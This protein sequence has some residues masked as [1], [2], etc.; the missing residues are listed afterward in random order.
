MNLAKEQS[1]FHYSRAERQ[2]RKV[3]NSNMGA[4][5]TQLIPEFTR[6]QRKTVT[7]QV[8]KKRSL[9]LSMV[10][11]I[12]I[13][14]SVAICL[15]CIGM[16]LMIQYNNNKTQVMVNQYQD[17]M[18]DLKQDSDQ[19]LNQLMDQYNYQTIQAEAQAAGL[20]LDPARVEEVSK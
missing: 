18:S 13:I 1:Y 6:E 12:I 8:S 15:F 17:S 4:N 3:S 19:L 7:K 14:F 11:S 5:S 9:N 2:V 10:E 16:G 20:S